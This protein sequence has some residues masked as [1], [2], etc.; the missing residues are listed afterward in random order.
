VV[1]SVKICYAFLF[2]KLD[3]LARF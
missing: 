2:Q 1:S 3:Y